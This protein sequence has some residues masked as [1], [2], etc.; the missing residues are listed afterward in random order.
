MKRK[1]FLL[2]LMA[3]GAFLANAN[4]MQLSNIST[5]QVGGNV[6]I[7]FDL[8]WENSWKTASTN[9]M[10]GA[11]IFFKFKDNDGQWKPIRFS[12]SNISIGNGYSM[13]IS[14]NAAITG[15]GAFIHR[16]VLGFGNVNLTGVQ[17]GI[18]PLPGIFDVRG[19]AIEMVYIPEVSFYAG[20]GTGMAN[21]SYQEGNTL[22][23]YLING[24]GGTITLGT[25]TGQLN[26]YLQQPFTGNIAGF[27]SGYSAFWIMKYE[28]SQAAY[29]DFLNTLTYNQQ[30]F[31][32]PS[33]ILPNSVP[34]SCITGPTPSQTNIIGRLEIVTSGVSPSTPAVIGC[35][36]DNDLD[37]N[38]P[39]DGEWNA[40]GYLSWP[41]I[42]AYLDWSGLRP[43][44][45]LEFEKVCRGPVGVVANEYA[46]GNS[47]ISTNVY[48]TVNTNQTDAYI[49][50]TS[51]AE[52][53]AMYLTTTGTTGLKNVRGGIF[54]TPL[55]TRMSSG[56]G[57][58]GVMELSGNMFESCVT[59]KN[60]AGRS[61]SGKLGNGILNVNGDAD[62][63]FWPGING[64]ELENTSNTVYGGTIG[65]T[66][67]A[68]KIRRGGAT[69]SSGAELCVSYRDPV[70]ASTLAFKD[71]YSG[72]RGVRDAN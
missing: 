61:F 37:F 13:T 56:A 34:G 27:P 71:I 64:N 7:S 48:T 8:S 54:A 50:N 72:I 38:E 31:R 59:T 52:G 65:V 18:Q 32:F 12:G 4:N 6:I 68:G 25:A 67:N 70:V 3:G 55:S 41:D 42:A 17:A 1:L 51:S 40:M 11:W 43:M 44:T 47:Q 53:N 26:G 23:P 2:F 19:F 57:Y 15:V 46:W 9:N 66:T 30:V 20:D 60:A 21:N 33:G 29:R 22:A 69:M 5:S 35:N 45:E 36:W 58:Y 39:G 24:S 63:N 62:E 14:N 28:V 10:D 49:S 16:S